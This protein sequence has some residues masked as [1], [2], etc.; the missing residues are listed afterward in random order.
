MKYTT[1]LGRILFA[2]IFLTAG[3]SHFTSQDVSYAA[4]QGVPM[5]SLLVPFSGIMSIAGALSIM[6]GYKAKWGAWIIVAFLIP[7]TFVMHAFWN[8]GNPMQRQ[9]QMIM[10]MKNISMLGGAL[11]ITRLG[12]GDFSLDQK[13]I[14]NRS[15]Q[16]NPQ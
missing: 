2:L 6:L 8:V 11:I 1:L 10:F 5:A 16:E 3:F 4:S 14:K 7:V 9:L 15:L 13:I 12:S